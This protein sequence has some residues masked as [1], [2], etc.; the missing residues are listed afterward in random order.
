MNLKLYESKNLIYDSPIKLNYKYILKRMLYPFVNCFYNCML[1]IFYPRK[2]IEKKC[3]LAICAI[4]RDEGSILT[5]WIEYH[6]LIGIEHFYL[7]NNFSQDN[8]LSIL[9]P[10]ILKG[11]VTLIDWPYERAQMR[12]YEDCVKK[13]RNETD[14]IGFIDLDEFIV[15]NRPFTNLSQILNKFKKNRPIIIIYW[16]IFGSN[17]YIDRN[18]DNLIC[19]DF[20]S[21][22]S[23]CMNIGKYFYNTNYQYDIKEKFKKGYMHSRWAKFLCFHLPPVNIQNKIV[24]WDINRVSKVNLPVQ[25]NHYVLKSYNEFKER[26]ARRGGGVH[27]IQKGFHDDEYFIDHDN[28]CDSKDYSIYRFVVQLKKKLLNP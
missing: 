20:T 5:E 12:A 17:G 24:L 27:K 19:E 14:W 3:K 7:Y 23:K 16:K 21:S 8:F 22:S 9:Q 28:Y 13:F 1:N 25:I 26:K 4:F 11:E 10:Y 6:K 2:T 18:R 15:P